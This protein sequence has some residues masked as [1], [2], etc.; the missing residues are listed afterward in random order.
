MAM[1][2]SNAEN[3][4]LSPLG[5]GYGL[6]HDMSCVLHFL[7]N[8]VMGIALPGIGHVRKHPRLFAL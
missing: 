3:S 7:L 5:F 6:G 8:V 1:A 4:S 2:G